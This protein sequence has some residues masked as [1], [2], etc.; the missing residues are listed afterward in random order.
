MG[1]GGKHV[2]FGQVEIRSVRADSSP[3]RSDCV[4]IFPIL[5]CLTVRDFP[6]TLVFEL[7]LFG[8]LSGVNGGVIANMDWCRGIVSETV[9][10]APPRRGDFFGHPFRAYLIW[11]GSLELGFPSKR[12]QSGTVSQ[13]VYPAQ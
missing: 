1:R 10:V 12:E 7:Q 6:C 13:D 2:C 4:L 3:W 11:R 5:S 8:S 9:L